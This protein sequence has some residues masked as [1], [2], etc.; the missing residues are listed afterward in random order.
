MADSFE[1]RR[2]CCLISILFLKKS[3][4]IHFQLNE[5]TLLG[6]SRLDSEAGLP[7]F[8]ETKTGQKI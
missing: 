1:S 4:S 7:P 3:V 8:S 5:T 6:G 2:H